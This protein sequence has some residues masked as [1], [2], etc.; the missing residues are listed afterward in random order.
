M[1]IE[2]QVRQ[3][4]DTVQAQNAVLAAQTQTLAALTQAV[5]NIQAGTAPDLTEI[6][7]SLGLLTTAVER[8]RHDVEDDDSVPPPAPEPAPQ[9]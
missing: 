6:T 7:A 9:P 3:I 4:L 1:T 2:A 5:A 8:I